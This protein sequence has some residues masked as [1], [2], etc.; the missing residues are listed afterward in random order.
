[1]SYYDITGIAGRKGFTV[2]L[3]EK[4]MMNSEVGFGRRVLSVLE[5]NGVSFEHLPTGI[6]TMSV[7][8]ESKQLEGKLDRVVREIEIAVQPDRVQ[9]QD[10]MALVAV[11][12][13]GIARNPRSAATVFRAM[14]ELEAN[15]RMID[16]GSSQLNIIVGLDDARYE[17]AVRGLY[18]HFVHD[19]DKPEPV[20]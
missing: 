12:G 9:V 13:R 8:V 11:V 14:L 18:R 2:L 3:I 20:T 4:A 6:D 15:V 16:Q 7:V 19:G 1:M 10:G 17:D 5:Q